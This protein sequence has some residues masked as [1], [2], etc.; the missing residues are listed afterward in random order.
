MADQINYL[1]G[2]GERLTEKIEA[3]RKI[4][5]KRTR[6]RSMKPDSASRRSSGRPL[7]T[8]NSFL[9]PACPND[10]SIAAVTLHP[11]YLAKTFF[12]AG[13]LRSLGWSPLAAV[14]VTWF[15]EKGAN[16]PNKKKE[17]PY[18]KRPSPYRPLP[19]T[20]LSLVRDGLFTG[21]RNLWRN[22]AIA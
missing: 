3:P 21:G 9:R 18:G 1:L 5:K 13:L 2:F 20:F 11:A 15:Q 4:A 19:P 16:S 17:P 22:G 12:P 8:L 14:H 7:R 6:T 10:E